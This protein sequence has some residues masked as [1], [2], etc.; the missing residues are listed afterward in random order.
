MSS[1]YIAYLKEGLEF[2]E[3]LID[4][5]SMMGY[6]KWHNGLALCE[7]HNWQE[8]ITR[9]IDSSQLMI[10][11]ITPGIHEVDHINYAI[12]YAYQ[13]QVRIMPVLLIATETLW[14]ENQITDLTNRKASGVEELVRRI[15]N[16]LPPPTAKHIFTP[17]LKDSASSSGPAAP[18]APEEYELHVPEAV[19]T[20]GSRENIFAHKQSHR[21]DVLLHEAL[22]KLESGE[23]R[24]QIDAANYLGEVGSPVAIEPLLDKLKYR[25]TQ[26]CKAAVVALGKIGDPLVIP[27]LTNLLFDY[28]QESDLRE[29]VIAALGMMRHHEALGSL[30]GSLMKDPEAYV[31]SAA[32]RTIGLLGPIARPA[33]ESLI[34]AAQ[35]PQSYRVRR[36]AIRALG[37][38][39]DVEVLWALL[40]FVSDDE[41][42]VRHEAAYQIV[43]IWGPSGL[44]EALGHNEWRARSAAV[45][46]LGQT[47][48]PSVLPYLIEAI[49]DDDRI[50]RQAAAN[51]LEAIGD[52]RAVPDLLERLQ[53]ERN[54]KTIL[55]II[56]A[57]GKIG[58]PSA[59]PILRDKWLVDDDYRKREITAKALGDIAHPEAVPPLRATAYNDPEVAVR[60]AAVRALSFIKDRQV[61][62]IL[63]HVLHED[64]IHEVRQTA[65]QALKDIGTP[66]ALEILNRWRGRGPQDD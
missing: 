2:V 23:Y 29:A 33:I 46:A 28:T 45:W 54:D 57:L 58:H 12:E 11:L 59:L 36:A 47:R 13:N 24:E 5:L 42:E 21:H 18:A 64:D 20:A 34:K 26:V 41:D 32:A 31:R 62:L 4:R 15:T 25:N 53:F 52:E 27:N 35:M 50:V 60:V 37:D 19:L 14:P 8:K 10:V 63:K 6:E 16:I 49:N 7:A 55:L 66:E 43:H 9:A 30:I 38:I 22:S 1:I 51:A 3:A 39:N 56:S 44:K 65:V 17:S 40:E 48:S 61:L